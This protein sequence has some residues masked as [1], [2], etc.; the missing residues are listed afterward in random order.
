MSIKELLI[1]S[2]QK[3]LDAA[4]KTAKSNSTYPMRGNDVRHYTKLLAKL[5]AGE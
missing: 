1:A 4:I 3:Q 5:K 2:T